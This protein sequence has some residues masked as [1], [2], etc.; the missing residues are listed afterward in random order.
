MIT[1]V[2]AIVYSGDAER[3]RTFMRDQQPVLTRDGRQL[4]E[5]LYRGRYPIALAVTSSDLEVLMSQGLDLGQIQAAGAWVFHVRD[6]KVMR[7]TRYM[8]RDRA[9]ADLG[10]EE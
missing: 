6:G 10:L 7:M 8:E 2:H 3:V 1:G 4:V 5:W 9:L